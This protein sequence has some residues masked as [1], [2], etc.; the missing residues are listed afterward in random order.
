MR[1]LYI[2][3]YYYVYL[4]IHFSKNYLAKILNFIGI[5]KIFLEISLIFKFFI[6]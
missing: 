2:V 1:V 5:F 3:S 6:F 4:I